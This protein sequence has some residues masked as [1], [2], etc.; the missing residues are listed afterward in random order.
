MSAGERA[1]L[2]RAELALAALGLTAL[3]LM[4]IFALDTVLYHDVELEPQLA[5]AAVNTLVMVRAA[6]SLLRQLGGQRAFLRRLPVAREWTVD[7]QRVR[8]LPGRGL[9]AFCGGLLHPA[10]YISED[11]MRT[12]EA[13]LQAILAHEAHHCARRDPL[14]QLLARVVADALRP[15][16]PFASLAER[17]AALADLAADAATVDALGGRAPLASALL[18]FEES[19]GIA[20]ERVD[21]LLG[22][23][24]AATI[25]AAVL[26]AAL[27]ALAAIA[28]VIATM[29]VADWH[30]DVA[31]PPLLELGAVV[32]LSAPACVAARRAG[33]W[34]RPAAG[35]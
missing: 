3:L 26:G 1:A 16:P 13:E 31:L 10:I 5:L 19:A 27:L 21:R 20:P 15:L 6:T 30:P 32:V 9:R 29:L 33:A 35:R 17:Q 28:A 12:G 18:R 24:T 22:T 34:L 7:G 23:E 2:L 25:P 14:R 4:G 11:A 8:V